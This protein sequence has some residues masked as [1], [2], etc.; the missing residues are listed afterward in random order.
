MATVTIKEVEF[1]TETDEEIAI[2]QLML[3][4]AGID[5]TPIY[6]DQEQI[7]VPGGPVAPH[8]FGQ[9][10]QRSCYQYAHR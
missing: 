6:D 5:L 2:A 10:H 8:W 9:W 7:G 3:A 4:E 1:N